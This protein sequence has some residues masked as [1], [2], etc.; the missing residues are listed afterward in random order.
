[1]RFSEKSEHLDAVADSPFLPTR[2]VIQNF[3][4]LAFQAQLVLCSSPL[5]DSGKSII[6]NLRSSKRHQ[7][8]TGLAEPDAFWRKRPES[9]FLLMKQWK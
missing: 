3:G 8:V 5:K 9:D 2:D 4:G 1:V 7:C 6:S